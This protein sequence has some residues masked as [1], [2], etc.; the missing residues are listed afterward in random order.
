MCKLCSDLINDFIKNFPGGFCCF[1]YY[2][3][4][5]A[6]L[7]E[8]ICP[9]NGQTDDI[10]GLEILWGCPLNNIAIEDRIRVKYQ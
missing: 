4:N 1:V 10:S 7:K 9:A 2:N 6:A 8:I 5:S 3:K